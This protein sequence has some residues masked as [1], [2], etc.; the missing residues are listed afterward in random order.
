MDNV[1]T[2]VRIIDTRMELRSVNEI[3]KSS[4]YDDAEIRYYIL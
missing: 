1:K 3:V 2:I 4:P